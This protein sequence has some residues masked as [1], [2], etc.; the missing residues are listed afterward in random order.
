MG[1][2][3][4]PVQFAQ[5]K[6]MKNKTA[7]RHIHVRGLIATHV[8]NRRNF[9]WW[10]TFVQ[11]AFEACLNLTHACRYGF[12]WLVDYVCYGEAVLNCVM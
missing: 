1:A 2:R 6:T 9:D 7:E 12:Q 10:T 4:T 5:L 11:M 8:Q 3:L